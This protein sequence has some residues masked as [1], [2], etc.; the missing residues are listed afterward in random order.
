MKRLIKKSKHDM[1]NR[2][3]A[4]LYVNG[5]FYEDVNHALCIRKFLKDNNDENI[6]N[7][8]SYQYRPDIELAKYISEKYGPAVIAHL[9]KHEDGIFIVY[10]CIDGEFK[11]FDDI[12]K[13]IIDD[14]SN[15]YDYPCYDDMKHDERDTINMYDLDDV[16]DRLNKRKKEVSK[17]DANEAEKILLDGGFFKKD[18]F[19]TNNMTNIEI[20]KNGIKVFSVG[21]ESDDYSF[22]RLRRCMEHKSKDCQN[23]ESVGAQFEA[24][25][26]DT[27]EVHFSNKTGDIN[28]NITFSSD[29][30]GCA[31]FTNEDENEKTIQIAQKI[32]ED[33]NEDPQEIYKF[34]TYQYMYECEYDPNWQPQEGSQ[35]VKRNR[36]FDELTDEELDELLK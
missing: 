32:R 30:D 28:Y 5:R 17:E 10:G 13:N 7:V 6:K 22:S 12:P 9:V 23:L 20:D 4:V 21:D 35:D 33:L 11:E 2:D 24:I 25:D 19:Y 16:L 29:N 34:N 36:S 1:P 31:A 26:F 3:D 14:I 18:D 15:H 8:T 27:I